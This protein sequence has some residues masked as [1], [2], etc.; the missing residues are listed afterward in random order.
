MAEGVTFV[1]ACQNF[2]SAQPYGKKVEI[3]E[4]RALSTQD[5]IELSS[6]LN[7]AGYSHEPYTGEKAPVEA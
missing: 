5:K 6:M 7:E 4:F 2:F 3:A 1:R